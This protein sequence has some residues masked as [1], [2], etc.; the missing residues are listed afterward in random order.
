M[1]EY[2]VDRWTGNYTA[3][4]AV[5]LTADDI[6]SLRAAD[7]VSFFHR[8]GEASIVAAKRYE[9]NVFG[10]AE[11]SR[12]IHPNASRV[13][14]YTE[15]AANESEQAAKLGY[16]CFYYLSAA[17]MS[18]T[19]RTIAELIRLGDVINLLWF[20]SNNTLSMDERGMSHDMLHIEL[21]R[22]KKTY[23]FHVAASI[24]ETTSFGRMVRLGT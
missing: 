1:M 24:T 4:E 9:D 13:T 5:V 8:D 16:R 15:Y 20:R 3:R 17:Q 11:T 21:R 18:A 22:G 12:T 6:K 2:Q 10:Y 19:W 23:T 14:N 7:T